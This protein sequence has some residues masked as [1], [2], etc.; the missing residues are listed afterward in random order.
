MNKVKVLIEGYAHPGP[1]GSYIASP[2]CTLLI[3]KGKKI[4]VDPGANQKLLQAKLK[5]HGL[6]PSDIDLIFLSHFH[7]D[8]FLAIRLFPNH[9]ILDSDMIWREDKEIFYKGVIPGTEIEIIKTPGHTSEHA[10]LIVKTKEYG[11]VCIAQ[12]LFWWEDGKQK[13]DTVKDLIDLKDPYANDYEALKKSREKILKIANWI[14]PG[15]GKM[16]KNPS[17]QLITN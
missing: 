15:H 11:T 16:F 4:I 13:S 10:S 12:D 5:N 6:S 14:I 3:S 17:R 2:S 9:D 7:P 1:N 8:H